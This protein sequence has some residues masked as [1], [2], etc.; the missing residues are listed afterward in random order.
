[1]KL[2]ACLLYNPVIP[3]LNN[4]PKEIET[5]VHKINTYVYIHTHTNV[6]RGFM[7]H[8]QKLEMT[9]LSLN[10]GMGKRTVEHPSVQGTTTQQ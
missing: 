9:G 7:R 8:H 1:M 10:L 5:Y 2:N 3:P 4:Y 6:Y